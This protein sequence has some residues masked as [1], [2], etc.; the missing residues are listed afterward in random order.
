MAVSRMDN[1]TFVV[2]RERVEDNNLKIIESA[3]FEPHYVEEILDDEITSSLLKVQSEN[4]YRQVYTEMTNFLKMS[5]YKPPFDEKEINLYEPIDIDSIEKKFKLMNEGIRNFFNRKNELTKQLRDYENVLFHVNILAN[6]KID[7]G[8]LSQ[9]DRIKLI[10]GRVPI[11]NYEN[12]I[13]SSLKDPILILEVNRDR[14]N[15]WLFVFT[16][17]DFDETARKILQSAYFEEDVLPIDYKGTPKEVK[18]RIESLIEITKISINENDFAIKKVLYSNKEFIDKYYPII[19]G[20]KRV[21]DLHAFSSSTGALYLLNGWMPSKEAKKFSET[22]EEDV[23]MLNESAEK[24]SKQKKIEVPVKI[25]NRG[26]WLRGFEFVTKMFGIPSY[27][28]ID[29]TPFVAAFFTFMFGFMLGDIGHGAIL[30]LFGY[31]MYKRGSKQFGTVMMSAASASIFFGFMYGS[32]FGFEWLPAIWLR[33]IIQINQLMIVGIYYGIGMISF[34]MILNII[35]GFRQRNWEKAL[36]S[37]EGIA[38]LVFYW[39]AVIAVSFYLFEGK[40]PYMNLIIILII[41]SLI[42]MLLKKPLG[43]IVAGEKI[44]LGEGFWVETGF[45]MFDT[46]I[47]F[48]SNAIS[49]VRLAAFALTHEALFEAF[50]ITTLMVLPARGGDIWAILIFL[51]GQLILVGLEGLVVFIQSLRL[52]YYEFFTKFFEAGGREFRPFTFSEEK[53]V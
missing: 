51:M 35:N 7:L 41:V 47:S 27:G 52:T 32:V 1:V 3:A 40:V 17:P 48:L 22:T 29:P 12:L 20:H 15:S 42:A 49:Y 23:L 5:E 43:Q 14:D 36:F 30:F 39:P 37:P 18:S 9:I 33:P 19:L 26:G 50:W 38:G 11:R 6:L 28:E 44:N 25:E 53:R 34:G 16:S 8:D 21:Y 46:L 13:E 31:L 10:F 2:P 45:G 24:I 4:P